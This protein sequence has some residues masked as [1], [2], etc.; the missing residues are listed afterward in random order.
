M[1]VNW[2][3][4]QFVTQNTYVTLAELKKKKRKVAGGAERLNALYEAV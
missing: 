1:W 4:T 2:L 3:V